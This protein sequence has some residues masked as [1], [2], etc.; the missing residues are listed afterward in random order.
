MCSLWGWFNVRFPDIESRVEL[1]KHLARKGQTR[2]EDSYSAAYMNG[3]DVKAVRGIGPASKW[4]HNKP[5]Q[6]AR[7]A[8]SN[9][10]LGHNRAA[11]HGPITLANAHAFH[12]GRWICSHNGTMYGTSDLMVRSKFVPKGETDSEEG[13]C[14]LADQEMRPEA[15]ALLRGSWAWSILSDDGGTLLLA[16]N[17]LSPLAIARV[18]GGLAWH[19]LGTALETSLQA[20]GIQAEVQELEPYKLLRWPDDEVSDIP[21]PEKDQGLLNYGGHIIARTEGRT[22]L[23]EE[24]CCER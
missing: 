2:G 24:D 12:V 11:S 4:L 17:A 19:S 13:L 23:N 16:R 21:T 10:V 14:Y 20:I 15:F 3:S 5:R 7:V 18:E 8:K 1:L 6:V 9:I 22:T